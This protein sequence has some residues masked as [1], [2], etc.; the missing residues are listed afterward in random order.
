MKFLYLS[1]KRRVRFVRALDRDLHGEDSVSVHSV[2]SAPRNLSG[3]N[4]IVLVGPQRRV[5]QEQRRL[6]HFID[7]AEK[8]NVPL[9][10]LLVDE[11]QQ[12]PYQALSR[13]NGNVFY[14]PKISIKN[15]ARE[16]REYVRGER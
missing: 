6:C 2:H 16:L 3:F 7:D 5:F 4:G 14:T 13:L 15:L 1:E 12:L 11:A 10:L 8:Y 9:A